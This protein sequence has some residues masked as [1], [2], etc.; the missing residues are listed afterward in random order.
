MRKQNLKK[1]DDSELK[2]KLNFYR[3][4]TRKFAGI[5]NKKS[6]IFYEKHKKVEDELF[7]RGYEYNHENYLIRG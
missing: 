5:D 3:K 4:Q 6:N 7:S 1:L 2:R